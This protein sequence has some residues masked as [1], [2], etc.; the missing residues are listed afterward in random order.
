MTKIQLPTFLDRSGL[1]CLLQCTK[2]HI[3]DMRRRGLLPP[4]TIRRGVGRGTPLWDE[5]VLL[6]WIADQSARA[7]AM[8]AS[9][10]PEA[11]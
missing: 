8:T 2:R 5:R 3:D 9:G 4:P 7:A 1:A 11:E 10:F 6:A